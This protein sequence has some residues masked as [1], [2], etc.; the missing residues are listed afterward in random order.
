MPKIKDNKNNKPDVEMI[1]EAKAKV[2]VTPSETLGF[3]KVAEQQGIEMALKFGC[4]GDDPEINI[5]ADTV[6]A[7]S[8][9][10]VVSNV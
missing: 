4:Y 9:S 7:V 10:G 1:D 6:V 5:A 3:N 2:V 8:V